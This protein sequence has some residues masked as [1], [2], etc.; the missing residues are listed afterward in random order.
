MNIL[1]AFL[2]FIPATL[3]AAAGGPEDSGLSPS[4]LVSIVV[5]GPEAIAL[6]QRAGIDIDHYRGKVGGRIE[7]VLSGAEM[8]L[9]RGTGL[10]YTVLVAD[11]GEEIARRSPAAPAQLEES[12]R[13]LRENGIESFGYGSM[14]GFYTYDEVSR[15]L[16]TLV[17]QHPQIVSPKIPIGASREGR[18]LWA[19]EVSD[20]PGEPE[21][22]EHAVYFDALHHAREPMSMA[23][24]MY[25]LCWLL[26]NYGTDLE[27]TYLVDHRRILFVPVVNPDGYVYNQTTNP[28]GGGDW[29]KNRSYNFDGSRGVD[30][31]RNYGYQWGYDN[32]GS[33]P[34][35]SSET[36][37]GATEWSEPETRAVRDFVVVNTPAIGFTT[38]SVA[39]RYLNPYGYTDTVVAYEYYAEFAG[40]F[41]AQNGYLYGTVYQ[42]LDYNSNGTTR[43][44]LHHDVNCY[45]WTPEIGGSGFWPPQ[46]TIVPLAQE[47]LLACRYITWAAGGF[48][49]YQ[50]FRL[51]GRPFVLPGDSLQIVV[52]VRNKGV[53]ANAVGVSVT[54]APLT[55]GVVALRTEAGYPAIPSR[56]QAGNDSLPF[57][58]QVPAGAQVTDELRFACTV[59]QEGIV[60]ARDTFTVVVGYARELFAATG[61][62]GTGGWV[63][64]GSGIPWDSS[65][66]MA[67][68]GTRSL[69]DSRYGNI[70]NSS[71]SSLSTVQSI[72]L[73]G[74]IRPRLEYMARW[75]N[76]SGYDYVRVQVSTNI[77]S[78]W[79][80]LAGRHTTTVGGS[81]GYTGNKGQ[82]A[83]EQITLAPYI[84]RQIRIR[85]QLTSDSGLRGDGFYV[86]ELRVLDY[87][88]TVV[89]GI[90]GEPSAPYAL[91][92][93][94]NYPNPFNPSTTIRFT[95]PAR[96][97]ALLRVVDPLGREVAVLADEEL[98]AGD[99]ERVFDVRDRVGGLASGVYYYQLRA[100]RAV[101]VRSLLLVK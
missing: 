49:D 20:N 79:T 67:F 95:L 73:T 66:V 72:D 34:T 51:A 52:Q 56:Q 54:L 100:G 65:S 77:G 13:I 94:Q 32:V 3:S 12:A 6:L 68:R 39:G 40:D 8:G 43:D 33:S 64:A 58:F 86:D 101:A 55:A 4:S 18:T 88:D 29:R 23:V 57:V 92:L 70:A 26:D 74:A 50:S 25:Y 37:R 2:L 47:N 42:M 80:S 46:S 78:S 81:P 27:A 69:A 75:S 53:R 62:Q 9:L 41:S 35:P 11:V 31:N 5:H 84:G 17:M 93:A 82:W 14:G 44:W 19:V 61:E 90:A 1:L 98:P 85:F 10:S 22:G 89:T 28:S 16:D 96:T 21:P 24:V 38:H 45:A 7:V 36:Y 76:E 59:R 48:A 15:K 99:H 30:L 91:R 97:H 60:T 63:R 87:R 71:S 83:W